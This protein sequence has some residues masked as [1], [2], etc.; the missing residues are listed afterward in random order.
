MTNKPA[1]QFPRTWSAERGGDGRLSA[2]PAERNQGP[3]LEVL[4]RVLPAK[5]L[6]LE[7]A[8]G[9]G[10]HVAHFAAALPKLDWQ[11]SDPDPELRASIAA[12][13]AHAGLAN[14]RPPLALDVG[15]PAWPLARA[16]AVL[17]I[18]M[19]H[20]APWAAAEALVAGAARLLGRGGVL[21]LY[22]PYRMGGRHTAESNAAFDADLRA[23][24]PEWGVR[25]LEAVAALA[26]RSGF[27]AAETV[28]MPANNFSVV[29]RK[30]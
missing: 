5:G 6:V 3:I 30:L 14:L 25:D 24:N 27:G 10:Q 9:T 19:I 20:I 16:E 28:A 4:R 2:P 15:A 12:W 26:E 13:I 7:I 11:P 22:G 18:N 1:I 8:S 23:R 29:F 17:C 21:Y